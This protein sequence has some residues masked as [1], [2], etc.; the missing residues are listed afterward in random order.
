MGIVVSFMLFDEGFFLSLR[1]VLIHTV[2]LNLFFM[3]NNFISSTDSCVVYI[4]YFIRKLGSNLCFGFVIPFIPL[5]F[6]FEFR[7]ITGISFN[8]MH[9]VLNKVMWCNCVHR[10]CRGWLW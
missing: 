2:Y 9:K 1:I 5:F 4:K 7:E 3:S 10:G 8:A 6:I